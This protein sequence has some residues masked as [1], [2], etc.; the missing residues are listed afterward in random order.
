L[1]TAFDWTTVA[2]AIETPCF[3]PLLAPVAVWLP[4]IVPPAAPGAE[5]VIPSPTNVTVS[6][7]GLVGLLAATAAP[8]VSVDVTAAVFAT[9]ETVPATAFRI[10]A[11]CEYVQVLV[12]GLL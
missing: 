2:G 10:I 9:T 4:V 12:S 6:E 3:L 8:T 7:V 5:I 11:F 1:S